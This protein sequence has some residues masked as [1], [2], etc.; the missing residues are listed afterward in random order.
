MR[1]PLRNFN[2]LLRFNCSQRFEKKNQ[3]GRA[4]RLRQTQSKG[5]PYP[6][7]GQYLTHAH[8]HIPRAEATM[9][10]SPNKPG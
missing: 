5:H 8:N 6:Q 10:M 7:P 1:P 9:L 4:F 3:L 2:D